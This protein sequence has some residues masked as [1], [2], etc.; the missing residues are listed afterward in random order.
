MF[1]TSRLTKKTNIRTYELFLTNKLHFNHF[2]SFS[3]Q[4]IFFLLR[5]QSNDF[6]T[7]V[8]ITKIIICRLKRLTV[9]KS[10]DGENDEQIK[11]ATESLKIIMSPYFPNDHIM[12]AIDK[13]YEIGQE[14]QKTQVYTFISIL[15]RKGKYGNS[16]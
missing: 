6:S 14:L 5:I 16:F 10:L 8:L 15:S 2:Y 11:N 12:D 1:S 7:L 13:H 3:G 9:S 4:Y